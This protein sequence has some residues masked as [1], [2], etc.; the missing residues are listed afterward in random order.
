MGKMGDVARRGRTVLFVSHNMAAINN[1]CTRT[2]VLSHGKVLEDGPT[3]RGISTYMQS[4]REDSGNDLRERKDRDGTGAV[5]FTR[6]WCENEAGQAIEAG[7]SGKPL[8]VAMEYESSNARTL[9]RVRASL[10]CSDHLGQDLFNCSSELTT[11]ELIECPPNGVIRCIIQ[12]LPLSGSDY[13]LSPFLE[14]N[15]EVQDHINAALTLSVEDGDFYGTGRL[16]PAGWRGKGVLVPHGW[17]TPK[18]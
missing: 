8:V 4:L 13:F 10:K 17:A 7:M 18:V 6:I 15:G 1:L 2:I 16:Y 5:R 14:V 3:E 12:A 11:K 9:N